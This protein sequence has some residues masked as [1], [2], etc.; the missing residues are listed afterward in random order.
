MALTLAQIAQIADGG[1]PLL[2][3]FSAAVRMAVADIGDE[4]DTTPNHAIRLAWAKAVFKD[5]K[6]QWYATQVI[7]YAIVQA[8]ALADKGDTVTDAEVV[9][10]VNTYLLK[11]A[12]LSA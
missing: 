7:D 4:P 10:I 9:D 1:G 11:V 8:T 5:R 2:S 3:R 12:K 6:Y